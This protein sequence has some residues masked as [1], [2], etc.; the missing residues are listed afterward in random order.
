M[1]TDLYDSRQIGGFALVDDLRGRHETF[2]AAPVYSWRLL[3]GSLM[4]IKVD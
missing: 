2:G 3:R 1:R 4:K